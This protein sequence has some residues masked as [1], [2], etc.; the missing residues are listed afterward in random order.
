MSF[1]LPKVNNAEFTGIPV[2]FYVARLKAMEKQE[3]RPSQ[4][5]DEPQE[6]VK[7]VFTI[8]QVIDS[9]DDDA[10]NKVGEELW[11]FTSISMGRKAKMRHWAEALLGR[12]LEEDDALAADDLIGKR[13]KVM[14]E[15]HTKQDG[16]KTTKIG[17][18]Q[19]YR[20]GNSRSSEPF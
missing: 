17:S 5:H 20:K 14:V 11:G 16:T 2:G 6:T 19:P 18:L 4:F 7:W 15:P 3:A 9:N 8:E 10:E 13:A 1:A 12:E